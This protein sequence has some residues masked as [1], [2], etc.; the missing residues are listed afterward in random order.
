MGL[1]YVLFRLRHEFLRRS[2][3]LTARF[4][5]NPPAI[6]APDLSDAL[7]AL[8]C[9]PWQDR[10]SM[11]MGSVPDVVAEEE[12]KD[13]LAFRI[14][15]FQGMRHQ[16][17][18]RDDW[19]RHPL[20][21]FV[22][23]KNRHWTKIPDMS[24]E[25]G[26]IKFV[27]ERGRFSHLQTLMRHDLAHGSDHSEWVFEEME[28]WMKENPVNCGPHYR[29]SQEISLR[30]LNWLGAISFYR[31]S[32]ALNEQRWQNIWHHL[33]WQ[34]HHVRNN[35]HFS[36]IAVRNN[37]AIT[38]TLMLYVFGTL[39]PA[40]PG[41]GE[42]KKS[43]RKW[44]EEEIAYQIYPDGSYLQFS[45]NYQRVVVQLL[46]FAL[47]FAARAGEKWS[48]LT[49]KR[50]GATLEFMEFFQDPVSGFLPNYGA[51]DGALFFRF[52][53]AA[54]RDYR[55]QLE[56]LAQAL[57]RM[58]K[59][60]FGD[61]F[62]FGW[63]E[64]E[65]SGAPPEAQSG[66]K[67]FP[68]GG[69][70]GIRSETSLLFFRSGS[71]RDRPSQADNHHMDLWVN[72]INLLRDAGTYK[73]N[74]DQQDIRFFFGTE[75]HNTVMVQGMDQMQKGPRFIWLNWSQSLALTGTEISGGFEI[76]GSI[77]AFRQLAPGIRHHRRICQVAGP[78]WLIEDRL[79]G[80]EGKELQLLWHPVPGFENLLNM[81]VCAADG[82]AVKP[83]LRQGW[84][85]D[86][87]G[88][89]EVAAYLVFSAATNA[90]S[91]RISLKKTA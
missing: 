66:M 4:P 31:N 65:N 75:S 42:W 25:A 27:W 13:I 71:H 67:I 73:Y 59:P 74:A 8:R 47:R 53:G 45:M 2:G 36:R 76:R 48:D 89:K 60:G 85:S 11:S 77:S 81:E 37:H 49:Y 90:F 23:D 68:D 46:T 61:A 7:S 38:E 88:Q 64:T 29:C 20:S 14:P 58:K 70:A 41:C 24:P 40:A 3:L 26:D 32:A 51:N 15:L 80:T 17:Q 19:H 1:R 63:P 86:C 54:F 50:A 34:V 21:G 55:P 6:P 72:G 28:S 12:V 78:E 62:W 87:Y 69:F 91:T 52:S 84:F 5:V 35:I 44:F 83:E 57:G 43:G 33:Y 9:W 30:V 82:K 56:A 22:Y 39:F 16:F 18:G 79:E 10:E